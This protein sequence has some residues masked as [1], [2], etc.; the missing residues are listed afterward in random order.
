[1]KGIFVD[2]SDCNFEI[3]AAKLT[4]SIL[5]RLRAEDIPGLNNRG[6]IVFRAARYVCQNADRE[7]E[8]ADL[9]AEA[10]CSVR[11]LHYAFSHSIGI[12]P[13]NY[14]RNIRLNRIHGEIAHAPAAERSSVA[15]LA[16]KYRFSHRG[17]LSRRYRELFGRLPSE[18]C[19]CEE[20]G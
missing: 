6:R 16:K 17:N 7:I 20:H 11:T 18:A 12:S 14:I 13:T 10:H 5:T 19:E 15:A 2:Q 1:M 3:E 8:L 4:H 9:A